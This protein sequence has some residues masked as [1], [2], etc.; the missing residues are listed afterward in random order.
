M[1]VAAAA[2]RDHGLRRPVTGLRICTSHHRRQPQRAHHA[3]LRLL[4][5]G[6]CRS[7]AGTLPRQRTCHFRRRGTRDDHARHARGRNPRLLGTCGQNMRAPQFVLGST[8]VDVI[9]RDAVVM[10][11]TYSIPHTT[12]RNT[13]H[14][15]SGAWTMLW[16]NQNGRWMIITGAPLGHPESTAPGPSPAASRPADTAAAMVHRH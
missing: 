16:R 9:T 14:T 5:T 2:P 10:T 12:P 7:V 1:A 11:L 8:Y 3:R 13:P 4:G 6:G 15:V